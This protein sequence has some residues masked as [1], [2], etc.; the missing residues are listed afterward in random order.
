[1][2]LNRQ[3]SPIEFSGLMF[4]G[5]GLSVVLLEMYHVFPLWVNT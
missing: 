5:C 4:V 1:M 3:N 2:Y